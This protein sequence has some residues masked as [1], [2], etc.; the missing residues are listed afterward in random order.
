MRRTVQGDRGA[1]KPI[2]EM[3]AWHAARS[4]REKA[5]AEAVEKLLDFTVH[6]LRKGFEDAFGKLFWIAV[7]LLMFS[8]AVD[9]PEV[10]REIMK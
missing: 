10:I 2:P 1:V 5:W 4:R 7:V 6:V 8:K 9:L 3:A